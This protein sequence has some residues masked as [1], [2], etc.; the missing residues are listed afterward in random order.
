[1]LTTLENRLTRWAVLVLFLVT[2]IFFTYMYVSGIAW[3]I[4]E[5]PEFSFWLT[6]LTIILTL[7]AGTVATY[8]F[9]SF[10]QFKEMRS[11]MLLL[12]G[13]NLVLWAFLYLMTH[14]ASAEW[15]VTFSDRDRNRTLG[16]ALVLIIVPCIILGSFS[17]DVKPN[18]PSVAL[19]LAWGGMLMPI[20]SL[21]LFFSEEPVFLMTSPEGGIEGLTI[22][23]MIISFGF[24][25]SQIIAGLRLIQKWRETQDMLDF[26]LLLAILVW[27]TGTFFIIILWDPLQ[28]A[29]LMWVGSI[30]LGMLQIS[31][32]QFMTSIIEPHRTLEEIVKVRTEELDLSKQESEFYL[33]LWTHKMGNLLQ[34]LITYLDLL[35]NVASQSK[36]DINTRGAARDLS[37]EAIL[38]NHQVLQ[39]SRIKERLQEELYIVEVVDAIQQAIKTAKEHLGPG[40]FK[41]EMDDKGPC[42]IFADDLLELVF[43][44]TIL[45]HMRSISSEPLE[46]SIN[47]RNDD[48]ICSVAVISDGL[49]ISKNVSAYL[50]GNIII[51]DLSLDLDLFTMKLLMSRY[52][53]WIECFRDETRNRTHCILKFSTVS[54]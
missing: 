18:R 22:E 23:G 3:N 45:F 43:L 33:N 7:S 13:A 19:L 28:V 51:G 30:I 8:S 39:L 38:V 35:E 1:M 37:R 52:D 27:I 25:I 16:M 41:I 10:S 31:V 42:T 53:G 11:L 36:E 5:P 29:E 12:L 26:A 2:L 20:I 17:G 44:S 50:Q 14:P 49:N 15:A 46:L 47:V 34:G 48:D 24:L 40:A 6:I 4:L 54:K 9:V 32:V 21:W